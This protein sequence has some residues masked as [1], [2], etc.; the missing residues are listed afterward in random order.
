MTLWQVGQ[1]LPAGVEL[2]PAPALPAGA[3]LQ[4]AVCPEVDL[5]L[6][7]QALAHREVGQALVAQTSVV[8]RAVV[9]M[10]TSVRP[11]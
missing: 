1:A 8:P 11:S 9:G 10:P 3:E 2:Q 7:L 6:Q 5:A 4:P